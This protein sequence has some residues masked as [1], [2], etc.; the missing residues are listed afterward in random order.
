MTTE[1]LL[2]Q[3]LEEARMIKKKQN[4][5]ARRITSIENHLSVQHGKGKHRAKFD[6][7]SFT[8]KTDKETRKILHMAED[9]PARNVAELASF[10]KQ[11]AEAAKEQSRNKIRISKI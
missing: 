5:M 1:D 9:T 4:S 11:A 10:W 3:I 8:C 7:M 2:K 6:S